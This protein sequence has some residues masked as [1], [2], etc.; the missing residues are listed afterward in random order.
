MEQPD[1]PAL[2]ER[3]HARGFPV[4]PSSVTYFVGRS[5]ITAREDGKGLP[6]LV[7][8]TFAFLAQNSNEAT[9]YL[10]LPTNNVVEIGRQ[11]AI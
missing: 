11:F 3:A 6:R 9:E 5:T 10:Q 2:L 8:S 1:L 4:D 7:E